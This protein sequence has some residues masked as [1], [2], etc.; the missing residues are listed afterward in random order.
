MTH[1]CLRPGLGVL[2]DLLSILLREDGLSGFL[3]MVAV[4]VV[5]VAMKKN[6]FSRREKAK[7]KKFKNVLFLSKKNQK[8]KKKS[9]K[10]RFSFSTHP[11]LPGPLLVGPQALR[12][13]FLGVR[14]LLQRFDDLLRP[15]LLLE[16]LFLG[17]FLV[18]ELPVGLEDALDRARGLVAASVV[19]AARFPVVERRRQRGLA[20]LL[21]SLELAGGR[22]RGGGEGDDADD[23]QAPE[24]CRV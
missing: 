6:V 16:L 3:L 8:K 4:V 10:E 14:E 20:V 13:G 22:G 17:L 24:H 1:L 18:H 9:T 23:S 19:L 11:C 12:R 5:V 7:K 15:L 2:F 21:G